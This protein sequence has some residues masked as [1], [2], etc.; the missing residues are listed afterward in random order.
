MP[1]EGPR[2]PSLKFGGVVPRSVLENWRRAIFIK[3][4]TYHGVVNQEFIRAI[5]LHAER[6]ILEAGNQSRNKDEGTLEVDLD[7]PGFVT[8]AGVFNGRRTEEGNQE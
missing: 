6:M 4:R 3:H 5:A 8:F 1:A 2:D 7:P